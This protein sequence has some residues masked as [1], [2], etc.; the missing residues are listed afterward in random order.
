MGAVICAGGEDNF[1]KMY[2]LADA[3]LY[4]AKN[5]GKSC[6]HIVTDAKDIA[7]QT[8]P[9]DRRITSTAIQYKALLDYMDGGVALFEMADDVELIYASPSY[10]TALGRPAEYFENRGEKLFSMIYK[11]DLEKLKRTFRGCIDKK[12]P[13]DITV[14][15]WSDTGETVWRHVRA[16][17]IPYEKRDNPVILAIV[18]DVTE[19]KRSNE[20]FEAIARHSPVGIAIYDMA[21]TLKAHYYNDELIRLCGLPRDRFR[22]TVANDLAMLFD[23]EDMRLLSATLEEVTASSHSGDIVCRTNPMICDREKKIRM[24][25]VKMGETGGIARILMMFSEV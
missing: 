3:A 2:K 4:A 14:R 20:M 18:T 10:I 19:L 7:A 6:Y 15:S 11:E 22:A 12:R 16:V 17:E 24:R 21:D 1:S 5:Q 8:E 9:C 23:P 13:M 25:G